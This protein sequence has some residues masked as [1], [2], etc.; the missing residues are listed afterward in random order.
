MIEVR[1]DGL[2]NLQA[3]FRRVEEAVSRPQLA[4]VWREL[5]ADLRKY[6]SPPPGSKYRRTYTLRNNWHTGFGQSNAAGGL[7]KAVNNTSYAPYVQGE[8]AQQA[9]VH[10][11]RWTPAIEILNKISGKI[12]AEWERVINRAAGS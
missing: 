1:I 12:V 9:A 8:P 6:P 10:R 5:L 4:H 2:Q 7:F 11:G 3:T